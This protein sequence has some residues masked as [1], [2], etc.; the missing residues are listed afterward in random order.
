MS[1]K[2]VNTY[3]FFRNFFSSLCLFSSQNWKACYLDTT[4]PRMDI[5]DNATEFP[6]PF[7]YT[8]TSYPGVTLPGPYIQNQCSWAATGT[9][10]QWT[11]SQNT[12]YLNR[13]G[14]ES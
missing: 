14:R 2:Q 1:T 13:Q 6:N 8:N 12:C 3:I 5:A 9:A 10:F 7:W 4:V 11:P